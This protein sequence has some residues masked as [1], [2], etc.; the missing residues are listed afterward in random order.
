MKDIEKQLRSAAARIEVKVPQGF[1]E[2]LAGRI[3]SVS[4]KD[5]AAGAPSRWSLMMAGPRLAGGMAFGFAVLVAVLAWPV[6]TSD[7]DA[8]PLMTR[9][10]IADAEQDQFARFS[11]AME[12]RAVPEAQ[13]EEELRRLNSDWRRIRSG[14]RSQVDPLL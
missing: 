6:L 7:R 10:A 13:L 14:V 11:A 3:E 1:S 8:E 9:V 2:R 5:S 4:G 12:F